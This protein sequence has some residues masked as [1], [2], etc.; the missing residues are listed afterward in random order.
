MAQEFYV[1][2]DAQIVCVSFWHV[3]YE[4]S[5]RSIAILYV[6][7]WTFDSRHNSDACRPIFETTHSSNTPRYE[8]ILLLRF[9]IRLRFQLSIQLIML[10]NFF[11]NWTLRTSISGYF[12][13]LSTLFKCA[14]VCT[15]LLSRQFCYYGHRTYPRR[16]VL[17]KLYKSELWWNVSNVVKVFNSSQNLSQTQ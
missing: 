9:K 8:K 15:I 6:K 11:I 2:K 5:W 1:L 16:N 7:I 12:C 17:H 14:V 4:V 13:D 3:A 10:E